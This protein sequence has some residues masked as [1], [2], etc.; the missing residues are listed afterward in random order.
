M[1]PVPAGDPVAGPVVEIFMADNTFYALEINICGSF[2]LCQNILGVENIE[3]LVFHCPHVEI[4]D[5]NDLVLVEI[6]LEPE[7]F[8]V[9]A[10]GVFK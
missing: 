2:R 5:S 7:S 10:H 1:K 8:L 6:I 4:I 3:A 9:P